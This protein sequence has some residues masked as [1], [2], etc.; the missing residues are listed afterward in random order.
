MKRF[1]SFI[2]VAAVS[3]CTAVASIAAE[4]GPKCVPVKVKSEKDLVFKG[5]ESLT[6]AV[7]YK[8][9]VINADI[10]KA[11]IKLDT[12]MLNGKKAFHASMFAYTQKAYASLFT[13]KEQLDSWFTRDGLVPMRFTRTAREGNYTSTN[14]YSYVWNSAHPHIKAALNNSRRGDYSADIPLDACTFDLPLLYFV[15]RNMDISSLSVGG[16]YPMTFAVD[17]DVYNL[18]FVYYGKEDKKVSGLGTVKCLKFGFQVVAGDVFAEGADLYAWF[19]DDGNHIPVMFA[20]PLKI[21]QVQGRLQM[22]TG[23]KNEFSSLKKR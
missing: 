14:S 8:L 17:D 11:T 4:G 20:A 16:R 18:H 19:T 12:A 1:F 15:L 7:N 13:V 2:L 6:F 5:G 23:L 22:F 9:G 10:A 21:G 3:L